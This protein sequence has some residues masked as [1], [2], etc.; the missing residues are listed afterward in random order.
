MIKVKQAVLP[1]S[2]EQVP[3]IRDQV[4]CVCTWC[5]SHAGNRVNPVATVGWA[6]GVMGEKGLDLVRTLSA[7]YLVG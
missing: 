5:R 3:S 7:W 2:S 6:C 4:C 1:W